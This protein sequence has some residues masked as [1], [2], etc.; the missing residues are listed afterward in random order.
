MNRRRFLNTSLVATGAA[1]MAEAGEVAAASVPAN[2]F[3]MKYAPHFG[4]FRHHAGE[5]FIDQLRFM[6]DQGFRAFEDNGMKGRTVEDQNRIAREL[7][8]LEMDMGVFVATADFRNVTF[9]SDKK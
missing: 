4:M 2:P 6:A 8:R 1:V 7:Q 5:D 9:A 3:R